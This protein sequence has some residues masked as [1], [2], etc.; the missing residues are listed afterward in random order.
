MPCHAAGIDSSA[1]ALELARANAELNGISPQVCSFK[2]EDIMDV[3]KAEL[4][5]GRRYDLIIL[6]P[7]KLAPN[8]KSLQRA[9]SRYRLCSCPALVAVLLS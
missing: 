7:P 5:A 6:D 3:M 1:P 2:Q 9:L 8:R 4:A